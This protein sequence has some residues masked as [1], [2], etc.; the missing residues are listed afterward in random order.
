MSR[1]EIV[2]GRHG[3][4]VAV[5]LFLTL[6]PTFPA[7]PAVAQACLAPGEA[8]AH[9]GERTCVEGIVTNA[10]YARGSTG[11]PTFLDFGT[12][13][14]AVIWGEDRA[15]FSPPPETLRGRRM[16]VSG[17]VEM[18]RGK[19]EIVIRDPSQLS[20]AATAGASP[21]APTT[22][23]TPRASATPAGGTT[24]PSL[25]PSLPVAATPSPGSATA[26]VTPRP[27]LSGVAQTPGSAAIPSPVKAPDLG[28]SAVPAA[29]T[30]AGG[31]RPDAMLAGVGAGAAVG[32]LGGGAAMWYRLRRGRGGR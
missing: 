20:A 28:R 13:F 21:A 31:G 32:A 17:T 4:S 6:L 26:L 16:R 9:A 14:T 10:V 27:A 2:Y 18:F 5:L 22:A 24:V 11:Q 30:S 25:V 1:D 3:A 12:S 23:A 8:A 29:G 15:R 19:A 7:A